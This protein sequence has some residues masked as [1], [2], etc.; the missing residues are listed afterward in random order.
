MAGRAASSSVVPPDQRRQKRYGQKASFMDKY[1]DND[2]FMVDADGEPLF[3]DEGNPLKEDRKYADAVPNRTRTGKMPRLIWEEDE[4][5]FLYREIQKCPINSKS[6]FVS[7]VL[8]HYGNPLDED[9]VQTLVFATSMQ[10]RDQMK[11]LVKLRN[12][13]DMPIVGNARFFLPSSDPRKEQFDEERAAAEE[14]PDDQDDR[15]RIFANLRAAALKAQA[16]KRKRKDSEEEDDEDD[17]PE[18][19]E[20]D[21]LEQENLGNA[22]AENV[23]EQD[24]LEIE[25]E[26]GDVAGQDETMSGGDNEAPQPKEDDAQDDAES[27]NAEIEKEPSPAEPPKRVVR[28]ASWPSMWTMLILCFVLC[29]SVEGLVTGSS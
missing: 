7:E 12:N 17:E 18:A 10:A 9:C 19:G 25:K 1:I 29:S 26:I 2:V 13:R 11:D 3:D 23:E 21:E 20:I 15:A 22:P 4:K 5:I 28:I 6:A 16:K 8:H 27:S 24:E 14:G